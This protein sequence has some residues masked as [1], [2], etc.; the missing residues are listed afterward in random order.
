M[1]HLALEGVG[2]GC[3]LSESTRSLLRLGFSSFIKI[4]NEVKQGFP[5]TL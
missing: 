4:V 5:G 2:V 3:R 1:L